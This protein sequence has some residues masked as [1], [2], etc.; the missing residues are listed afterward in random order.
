MIILTL[1]GLVLKEMPLSKERITIGRRPHNDIVI[2][3][4]AISAEHAV[5]VTILKDSFLEDLNSTNGTQI[6]GQPVKK[7]FLQDHDVIEL[8]QYRLRYAV[9]SRKNNI[10]SGYQQPS[11]PHVRGKSAVDGQDGRHDEASQ[12]S[13]NS[14]GRQNVAVIKILNGR[15]AGKEIALTKALTTIGHPGVQVAVITRR[16][17]GYSISHVEGDAHPFVN[18]L[19]IGGGAHAVEHGDL[20]DLSGT[21]MAFSLD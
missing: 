20:I 12:E 18:G 19:A 13:R 3:D 15:N 2:D 4:L 10:D 1:D 17:E 9:G 21:Q 14:R 16:P 6:N 7:H 8:A 5:I 11:V